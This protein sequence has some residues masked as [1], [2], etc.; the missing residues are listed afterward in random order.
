MRNTKI[1]KMVGIAILMAI[2]IVLQLLGQFIKFGPVSVSLVLLPIVVGA[3]V[4]GPVAGAILGATFGVVVLSQP[5]TSFFYG[6]SVLGTIVIVMAKGIVSG[7]LAGLAYKALS[8]KSKTLAV[9][10][11]AIVCPVINTAIFFLGCM[12]FFYDGLAAL[13]TENV[14]LFV[15]TTFIG[16]NFVAEFL[17]NVLCCPVILR[18]LHILQKNKK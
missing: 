5:D 13:G 11:S 6:I 10:V 1:Q 16:I 3:A 9:T 18:L 15:I 14:M 4:Y 12:T 8:G 17:V 2:V 7:W